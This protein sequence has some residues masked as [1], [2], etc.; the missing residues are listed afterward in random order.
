MKRLIAIL[1]LG[2]TALAFVLRAKEAAGLL[3]CAC[4]PDCWC[5]KPGLSVFRW[6]FP[7]LHRNPGLKAQQQEDDA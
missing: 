5:R 6:V 2:Y 7:H 1:A 4:Y 3:T